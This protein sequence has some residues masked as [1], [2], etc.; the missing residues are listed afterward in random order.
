MMMAPSAIKRVDLPDQMVG[1]RWRFQK[2][3]IDDWLRRYPGQA[4]TEKK[5]SEG[6]GSDEP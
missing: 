5:V 2:G 6:G 3:A 1:K 4:G